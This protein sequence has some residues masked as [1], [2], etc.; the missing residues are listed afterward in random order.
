V[1]L[2]KAQGH[3]LHQA[4]DMQRIRG[5]VEADIGAHALGAERRVERVLVG[6]LENE[7]ARRRFLKKT[8]AGNGAY[9]VA[10]SSW[11]GHPRP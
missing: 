10:S 6:A 8:A 4:S 1:P 7:A 5:A 9:S 11:A 3:D 2:Q